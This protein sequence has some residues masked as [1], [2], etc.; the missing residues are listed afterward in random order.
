MICSILF[1]FQKTF[2]FSA[3]NV[4]IVLRLD[5]IGKNTEL[6]EKTRLYKILVLINYRS[7]LIV[8]FSNEYEF[9]S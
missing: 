8:I 5:V 4:K 7:I 9:I 6:G 3:Q 1:V 2:L